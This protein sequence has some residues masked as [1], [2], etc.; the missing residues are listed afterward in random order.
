[1]PLDFDQLRLLQ[2]GQAVQDYGYRDLQEVTPP[3]NTE[4]AKT[5]S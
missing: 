1:M 2:A 4:M 3:W 5:L